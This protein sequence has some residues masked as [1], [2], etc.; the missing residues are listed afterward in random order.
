MTTVKPKE[1]NF[2]TG[3]DHRVPQPLGSHIRQHQV[4]L[5]MTLLDAEFRMPLG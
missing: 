1:L 3:I 5:S 2:Q 4:H